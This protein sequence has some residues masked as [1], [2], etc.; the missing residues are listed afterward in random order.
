MNN[1]VELIGNVGNDISV[2]VSTGGVKVGNFS[3][4]VS[5][6]YK[7]ANGEV[8]ERTDWFR[9]VSFGEYN[10]ALANLVKKGARVII[11][12]TLRTRNY[13]DKKEVNHVITEIH[14]NQLY[15]LNK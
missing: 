10:N 2:V 9:V 4:A 14:L 7:G 15:V 5:D 1:R 6:K 3:L 8:K 11:Y 12:G 13:V